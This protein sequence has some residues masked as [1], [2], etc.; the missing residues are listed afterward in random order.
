MRWFLS[1][2]GIIFLA[3][4]ASSSPTSVPTIIATRRTMPAYT[5]TL[6]RTPTLAPTST[7]AP[8]LTPTPVP[9]P[10][11]QIGDWRLV[12]ADE[13]DGQALDET[14]WTTCWSYGCATTNPSLWYSA[15]NVSVGSGIVRLRVDKYD[16][17]QHGRAIPYTSGMLSTGAG[18]DGSSSRFT[19]L[20]G[21][22]EARVRVPAGRGLWPAFWMLSPAQ[23]PPEI[24]I[25]E[26]LSKDPTRVHMHYHYIDGT[27]VTQDY[28]AAWIGGDFST[29]WHTFG[30]DW[31]PD[32]IIW[33][34]DGLER[35]RYVGD[36]IAT[37]PLYLILNLQV[38]DKNSW[39]GPADATTVF[40]AYYDI[41]YVR[42]WQP[43]IP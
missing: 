26:I 2:I 42:A 40:P 32:A 41:D 37:E 21:Y 38:G 10:M 33:Y 13:F 4:C 5:R 17:V 16:Q 30:V 11:G 23:R 20:Y 12:F 3:A 1:L 7:P 27:G 36:Y 39:P 8:T 19:A 9:T 28:G 43:V 15:T 25:M 31:R 18:L 24:D 35:N 22:F 14:K 29:G 6:T 34:V